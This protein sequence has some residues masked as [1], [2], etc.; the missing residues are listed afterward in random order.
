MRP[1]VT[2]YG[3]SIGQKIISAITGL[4]LCLFL[5]VHV[6]GNLLLFKGDEGKAFNEYVIANTNSLLIRSIEIVLFAG[7]LI[8]IFWG[9]RVWL[10][11]RRARPLDYVENR[12]SENSSLPSRIM[13]ITG[14]LVILFLVVHLRTFWIAMRF[15]GTGG[16]SD[17]EL[18]Q[19][20]FQ[21]P[22]YDSF[23]IVCMA[24]LAY[25][26]R[27]GF[28][29]AFQTLG[30]RPIWRRAID[31]VA[32]IFWL[33]IPIGFAAMPVYFLIKGAS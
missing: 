8:H 20:T 9:I 26:L 24:I 31:W 22:L 28:Q 25:H 13:F 12:P 1:T 29:S 11:N 10:F 17:Y 32:V 18:V 5:V 2:V 33:I 27:Q 3:S 4:F 19:A 23:Y 6:S 30:L 7:F 21:S 16:L 15:T 14:M